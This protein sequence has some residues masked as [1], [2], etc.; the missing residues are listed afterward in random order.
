MILDSITRYLQLIC[1]V[2]I[3]YEDLNQTQLEILHYIKSQIQKKDILHLLEIC[4][5]L[6]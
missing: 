6:I 5:E 2:F 1:E 3:M 4:K